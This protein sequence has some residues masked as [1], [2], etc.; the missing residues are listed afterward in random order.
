MSLPVNPWLELLRVSEIPGYLPGFSQAAVVA[1]VKLVKTPTPEQMS[2]LES[3]VAQTFPDQHAASNSGRL[4]AWPLLRYFSGATLGVLQQAGFPVFSTAQVVNA[5]GIH[6]HEV[7]IA[8]PCQGGGGQAV[9][10]A[11]EAVFAMLRHIDDDALPLTSS[12]TAT[13]LATYVERMRAM[14]PGGMNTLKFLKA[15]ADLNIP[16]ARVVNNVYQFGWGAHARLLDSSFTDMTSVIGSGLARDK[17]AAAA[18]LRRAGIPVPQHQL[19]GSADEALQAASRLGYPIVVKPAD[20]DG[21]RGVSAFLE[22]PDE[23]RKA[24]EAAHALSKRVLVE[25]HFI[26]NDYRLQVFKGTVYWAT[27][28]IP[29]GVTGDGSRTL[30]QLV[31]VANA[32]PLRGPPGKSWYKWIVVDEEAEAWMRR[33]NLTFDS[34]PDCGKFVRL[35]GAANVAAGGTIVPVLDKAHPDNLALAVRAANLLRLDLAGIDLLIPDIE[36]SWLDTGAVICEVN[37]KPQM[38]PHLPAFLLPQ[39]VSGKGRVPVV[40]VLGKMAVPE[41]HDALVTA[42]CSVR[43]AT[44][45]AGRTGAWVSGRQVAAASSNFQAAQ[46]LLVDTAVQAIV[47]ELE[48]DRYLASGCPVDRL[49][50]LILA[51]PL[52]DGGGAALW[53]ETLVLVAA[54]RRLSGRVWLL[55]SA[56]EWLSEAAGKSGVPPA[57]HD[58]SEVVR[59][60]SAAMKVDT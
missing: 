43:P 5:S 9:L 17:A 30:R 42:M 33:Q 19:V 11:V 55:D 44:G 49:D 29:A 35:R 7:A 6:K 60:V 8:F 38:S 46:A 57:T 23:V 31:D 2:R 18:M 14:A 34:I 53:Q 39:L 56:K 20:L 16:W 51:G 54:L 36:R 12:T 28:R 4:A 40:A 24:F 48:D 10:M 41:E 32:D 58:V 3:V 26:G 1:M 52:R 22:T 13:V 25:K 45:V 47:L 37:A 15:A 21:G 27:H 50:D 59:A